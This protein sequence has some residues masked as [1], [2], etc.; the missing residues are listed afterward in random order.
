MG[1]KVKTYIPKKAFCGL[2]LIIQF[3]G[4]AQA[5]ELSNDTL[6]AD[7]KELQILQPLSPFKH[8]TVLLNPSSENVFPLNLDQTDQSAFIDYQWDGK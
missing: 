7:Q 2:F 5:M 4:F 3:F 8:Q 6:K 1:F